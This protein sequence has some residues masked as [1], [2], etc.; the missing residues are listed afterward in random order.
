[1][2]SGRSKELTPQ[3]VALAVL[4]LDQE[5]ARREVE[6]KVELGGG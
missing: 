4:V 2:R 1:M 6:V 5:N 3:R